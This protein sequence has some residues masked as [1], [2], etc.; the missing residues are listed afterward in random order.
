MK[1]IRLTKKN[2]R[3]KV[4]E[5]LTSQGFHVNGHLVPSNFDKKHFRNIQLH[6]RNEQINSQKKFLCRN[7]QIIEKYSVNGWDVNPYEIEL[8]L[9]P[10]IDG[11]IE[12]V[13]FRWW[14]LIWWSVP[15]QKAYGRQMRFIIWDKKHN[16]PFGLIGLQSPILRMSVRDQ[17]LNIPKRDLDYWINKSMQAQRL[18]ALPPYNEIIGGKMTALALTSNELRNFYREKYSNVKTVIKERVIEPE[19][20]FLTTTSA[21]GRSSIYNRLKY[22]NEIVAQSLGFTKGSGSFHVSQEIY[23]YLKILLEQNHIDTNTTFGFG[24]SRKVKLIDKAFD[25]LNLRDYHYHNIQREFFLFSLVKNLDGVINGSQGPIYYDRPLDE[26]TTFW[27]ERWCYPRF[28]RN[29]GWIGFDSIKFLETIK[30]Q[31]SY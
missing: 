20:L 25:L 2:L 10:V 5:S 21:F 1:P 31:L 22:H 13:L 3:D 12:A 16:A 14:N 7:L 27:K 18:G 23:S 15:Y 19:L 8:E 29:N 4:I 24:P 11:T 28:C 6:S 30:K 26:L 17:H 9:R